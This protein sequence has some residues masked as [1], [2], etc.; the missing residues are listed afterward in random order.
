MSFNLYFAGASVSAVRDVYKDLGCCIL[1][2]QFNDRSLIKKF[3]DYFKETPDHKNKLMVDS[4]A[5]TAYTK[6]I[7]IDIDEYC[8]YINEIG[9]YVDL[10]AEVDKIPGRF[11]RPVSDEEAAEAPK[12]SWDNYIYMLEH[13]EDRFKDKIIPVFHYGEDF[14]YLQQILDYTFEDGHHIQYMGLG[15]IADLDS[16]A[17]RY[18]WFDQCFKMIRSSANPDIKVHAFGMTSLNILKDFPIYSADS[19]T[20]VMC[21]SHGT[22]IVGDKKLIVSDRALHK[23]GNLQH[24]SLA[25]RE[26]VEKRVK[27]YGFTMEQL[28]TDYVARAV[29]NVHSLQK[30]A[31]DYQ[32]T[33][34]VPMHKKELF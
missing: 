31:D 11:G 2:S 6:G 17:D 3:V 21:S 15:A 9:D 20:W 19:T 8:R 27:E 34:R 7:D 23:N 1:L 10:F 18:N 30:W 5:W 29:F 26:E 22:I 33:P 12:I 4:G 13:V 25:V 32:Y 14:K 24:K 28:S 16:P